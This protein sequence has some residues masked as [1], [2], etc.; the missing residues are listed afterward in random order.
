MSNAVD[1]VG[2]ELESAGDSVEEEVVDPVEDEVKSGIDSAEEEVVDPVG[3]ELES[4]WEST[5]EEVV[6]PVGDELESGWQSAEETVEDYAGPALSGAGTGFLTGGPWGAAIGAG[7][8]GLSAK[9]SD[10]KGSDAVGVGALGGTGGGA[11]ANLAGLG[12]SPLSGLMGGSGGIS[13]IF[14]GGSSSGS[15]GA[16]SGLGVNP[17][18]GGTNNPYEAVGG[19]GGLGGGGGIMD[20]LGLGN[21]A[22]DSGRGSITDLFGMGGDNGGGFDW[23]DTLGDIGMGA[24]DWYGSE[25]MLED[26]EGM[27]K[28]MM[29][30][31]DRFGQYREDYADRLNQLMRDEQEFGADVPEMPSLLGRTEPYMEDLA[32]QARGGPPDFYEQEMRGLLEDPSS[33]EESPGFNYM[34]QQMEEGAARKAGGVMDGRQMQAMQRHQQSFLQDQMDR[35]MSRLSE[36]AS[37]ARRDWES[38]LSGL[39]SALEAERARTMDEGNLRQS[40]FSLEE[41]AAQNRFS[42]LGNLAGVDVNPVNVAQLGANFGERA[43]QMRG[44]QWGTAG[45]TL[46]D[47]A[48]RL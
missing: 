22:S 20:M 26:Y 18:I 25:Q 23:M 21:L 37:H 27:Q 36:G 3:D 2:D 13:S 29:E 7:T 31:A 17:G 43:T 11:G 24:L 9:M 42:R 44:T 38:G 33:I 19:F 1:E 4:G 16:I 32:R 30:R 39:Q 12:S 8:G 28:D 48:D 41:S 45:R 10:R 14:G 15:P 35:R 34:Q 47:I 40:Q 6:D 5:K 46:A